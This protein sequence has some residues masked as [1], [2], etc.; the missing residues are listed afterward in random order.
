MK[1]KIDKSKIRIGSDFEMFVKNAEGVIISAIPYLNGTKQN[2]EQTT[3][4]GC[5]TQH[6]GVLAECNVPPVKI[7]Q[8]EDFIK[9]V[10]FVKNYIETSFLKDGQKLVCCASEELS[11]NEL[12][13]PQA[14]QIG[15][16]ADYNAWKDGEINEKP[17]T[18]PGNLRTTGFHL[19]FSYPKASIDTSIKLMKLFDLFLTIPFLFLDTDTRR[20]QLY[21]KAGAFRLQNWGEVQG[22]EAR[23][24]SGFCGDNKEYM[25]YI[26]NQINEMFDY[27]NANTMKSI[28][29][30]AENIVT[31]INNRDLDLAET[32][33]LKYN[34][35]TLL[36]PT[37]AAIEKYLQDDDY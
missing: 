14:N 30:D 23:T 36:L 26:F 6:D 20:R 33:C 8:V 25:Y 37:D 17:E 32:L 18:F 16:D 4:D 27:Y 15:C 35:K 28:E 24:L 21:G 10:E 22:F 9:N 13:D 34:I 7:D 3:I 12:L 29:E 19:H 2:P 1:Q 31:A 11:D 5:C